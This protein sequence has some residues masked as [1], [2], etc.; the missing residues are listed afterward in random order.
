MAI[1][2]WLLERNGTLE[3]GGSL[4]R[5]WR[6][7]ARPELVHVELTLDDVLSAARLSWRHDDLFDR[8]VV[9]QAARLGCPLLTRDRAI[10][11]WG[12]IEVV[13]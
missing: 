3:V 13:W 1:E 2:V 6:S 5:W 8:L 9:A 11:E 12:G 7:L 10:C 4:E